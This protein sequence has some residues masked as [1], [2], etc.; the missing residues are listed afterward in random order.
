MSRWAASA[1]FPGTK[2]A[3]FGAFDYTSDKDVVRSPMKLDAL[4]FAVDQLTWSFMD[5]SE[6]AGKIS[7]MWDKVMAST[8]FTVGK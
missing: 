3:L 6:N 2:N 7:L 1:P 8:A 4:A 5:M